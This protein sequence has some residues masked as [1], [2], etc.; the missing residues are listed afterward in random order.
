[1]TT[2]R[3]EHDP[4]M[5]EWMNTPLGPPA[6]ED[7]EPVGQ[8][9]LDLLWVKYDQAA[10]Q[11]AHSSLRNVR[12]RERVREQARAQIEAAI[13]SEARREAEAELTAA[14]GRSNA[15]TLRAAGAEWERTQADERLKTL[16]DDWERREYCP[17]CGIYQ[18]WGKD[19]HREHYQSCN[20][21]ALTRPPQS[22][23]GSE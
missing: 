7:Q 19:D 4:E 21:P 20:I 3:A 14:I 10:E 12:V 5:D 13:A 2:K 15:A 16:V 9:E 8:D 1:M 17:D 11:A 6:P 23:G 18:V 22:S